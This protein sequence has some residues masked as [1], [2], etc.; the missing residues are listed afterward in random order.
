[1]TK[2]ATF[3]FDLTAQE[4]NI[5]LSALSELPAKHSM[6]VI[7]KLQAQV[8]AQVDAMNR[9]QNSEVKDNV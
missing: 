2:E 9:Q 7:A 6:G 4:T 8:N 1:M 3:T 5:A